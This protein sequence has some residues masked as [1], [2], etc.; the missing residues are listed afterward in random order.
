VRSYLALLLLATAPPVFACPVGT[1]CAAV[2]APR[3]EVAAPAP[4]PPR[5]LSLRIERAPE[6]PPWDLRA[7]PPADT[8]NEMPWI[9]QVLRREVHARMPRYDDDAVTVVLSP[10][11]VAGTFDTVPGVGIA[12]DF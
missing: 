6:R 12:G 3:I 8:A 1:L 9:W 2:D 11:V 5:P 4:P 10:V 7:P